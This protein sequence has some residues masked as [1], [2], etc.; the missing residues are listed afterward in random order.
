ME[1]WCGDEECPNDGYGTCSDNLID[2]TNS[3]SFNCKIGIILF[4]NI[5]IN[6]LNSLI[7]ILPS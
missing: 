5:Y 2:L 7:L 3:S 4:F 6:L 1:E